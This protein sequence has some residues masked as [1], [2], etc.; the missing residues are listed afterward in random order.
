[1]LTEKILDWLNKTGFPLEM[2]TATE[3]RKQG[4]DISQSLTYLDPQSDKGREIDVLAS[5]SNWVGLIDIH[6]VV[7]CKSSANPWIVLMSDDVLCGKS[8]V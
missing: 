6:F 8:R 4:F 1:M 5:D 7:E 3:F 2:T